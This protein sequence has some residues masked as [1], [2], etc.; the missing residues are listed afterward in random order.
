MVRGAADWADGR[1][2][3]DLEGRFG[4]RLHLLTSATLHG[5]SLNT[6]IAPFND[7]RVRWALAYALDRQAVAS[8]WF[9]PATPTCQF[10][11]P[12]YPGYRP[13]CPYGGASDG[14]GR[15]LQ[16]DVAR[17]QRLLRGVDKSVPITVWT[18]PYARPA[19]TEVVRALR[20]L[21]YRHVRLHVEADDLAYFND[22]A[23]Q[24]V[25]DPGGI[26]RLG[27]GRRQP[28][29]LAERLALRRDHARE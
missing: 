21:G 24:S 22:V 9:T 1:G 19:F 10:L 27:P 11:P 16:T 8:K 18:T 2:V 3:A 17:G 25:P 28:E 5:L 7:L 26:L 6:A 4:A 13:Y 15:W 14:T 29:H 20:A 12:R 23:E